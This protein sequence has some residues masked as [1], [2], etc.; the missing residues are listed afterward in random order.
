MQAKRDLSLRL[1][2]SG[3]DETADL[4]Q[5]INQMLETLEKN[6]VGSE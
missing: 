1:S 4:T 6:P 3:Q 2:V 5:S